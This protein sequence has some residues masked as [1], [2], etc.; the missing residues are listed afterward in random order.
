[1]NIS[2]PVCKKRFSVSFDEIEEVQ[3]GKNHY[4]PQCEWLLWISNEGEVTP[5]P[6]PFL[7]P[8]GEVFP[9]I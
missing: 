9:S 2:C 1:M 3:K 4:C 5:V 6:V 7:V 8:E